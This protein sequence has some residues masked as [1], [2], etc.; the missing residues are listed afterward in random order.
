MNKADVKKNLTKVT[1][2]LAAIKK[3]DKIFTFVTKGSYLSGLGCISEVE[4][5]AELMK[6]QKKINSLSKTD[7]T[8]II[9]QLGLKQEELPEQEPTILGFAPKHWNADV[10]TKL[11]EIRQTILVDKLNAAKA[12]LEK[13]LSD[14]D[15]FE[16][17]TDG[18]ESL[19]GNV[20]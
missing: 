14:D 19:L 16:I 7:N 3:E 17:D 5:I 4:N 1:S 9:E 8:A 6:F 18:I 2:A 11:K 15:K 10:K 20:A 12:T 13:H